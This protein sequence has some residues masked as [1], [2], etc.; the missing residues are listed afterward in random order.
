VHV[1][2]DC[3]VYIVTGTARIRRTVAFLML[4]GRKKVVGVVVDEEN[5]I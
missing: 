2:L 1:F 5:T 4:P 3:G